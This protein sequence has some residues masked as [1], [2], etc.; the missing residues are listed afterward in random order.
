MKHVKLSPEAREEIRGAVS[1]WKAN[2]PKGPRL[3]RDELRTAFTL[4]EA[5][6]LAGLAAPGAPESSGIRFLLL[7][8]SRFLL[9]YS[10]HEEDVEVLRLW[11][12]SRGTRP[13]SS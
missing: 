7:R 11:H 8:G 12:T 13:F 6:P 5:Q 3:L 4:L 1:W 10:V 2:R 9:Y